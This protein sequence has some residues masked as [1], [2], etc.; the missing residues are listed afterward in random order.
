MKHSRVVGTALLY[1]SA[2]LGATSLHAADAQLNWHTDST[3]PARFVAV[4]GRRSAVFGY[5]QNKLEMDGLEI[6]AYPVQV[7]S[8]YNIAF[9]Q[10]GT[11]TEIDGRTVLRRIQYSPE[12]VTRVYVGPDFIV[13]ERL[14][15]PLDS[16]GALV[17]YEVE[18]VRPVDI[19]V[20]FTPVL[21][22]M[23]PGGIGGQEVAWN[24]AASGYW[25]SEPLRRY[26]ALIASPNIIAHDETPNATRPVGSGQF[27]G[28]GIHTSHRKWSRR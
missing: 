11:T 1:V 14:F 28:R 15:V 9:R 24:A 16:P 23:W 21:N 6:W 5:S 18:G 19:V 12:A 2:L 3:Q 8:A 26:T 4:H 10:Q 20:R 7:A 17:S 13:R 25:L 22:L 27:T